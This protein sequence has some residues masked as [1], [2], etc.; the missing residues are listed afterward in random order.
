MLDGKANGCWQWFLS[1]R[2][3]SVRPGETTVRWVSWVAR[4]W[5]TL[6]MITLTSLKSGVS[7]LP[8]DVLRPKI[9]RCVVHSSTVFHFCCTSFALA[10]F[11]KFYFLHVFQFKPQHNKYNTLQYIEGNLISVESIASI[12]DHLAHCCEPRGFKSYFKLCVY[13]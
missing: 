4:T 9:C 5:C 7:L 8:S 6:N 1:L 2:S 12:V 3:R 10:V 11:L 13:Y